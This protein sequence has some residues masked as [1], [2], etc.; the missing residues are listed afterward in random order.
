MF[1]RRTCAVAAVIVVGFA[2]SSWLILGTLDRGR[3]G[4]WTTPVASGTAG[5]GSSGVEEGS[6]PGDGPGRVAAFP[7]FV[8]FPVATAED[9]RPEVRDG[10]Y[11][12]GVE[13][14]G[15]SR[16]YPLNMLSNPERH[17]VNDDL[18]GQPI[19]V[20]WCG[21]CQ[22]PIV[23][24]RRMAGRTL[25]LQVPGTVYGENMVIQDAETGSEWPQLLGEALNGPLK[26]QSLQ[27][28]PSVWTAWKTWRTEHPDTSVLKLSHKVDY[29]RSDGDRAS[30]SRELRYLSSLQFGLVRG[31]KAL[32]VPLKELLR[33]PVVN[34]TIAGL[35]VVILFDAQGSTLTAFERRVGDSELT[36][37]KEK[38]GL[39]DDRTGSVWDP[40]TGRALRGALAGQR[41]RPVPGIV[42]HL[43]AWRAFHPESQVR[44][45]H[46]S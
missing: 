39:T 42:S 12:V 35:A 5:E 3:G 13:L 46:P 2:I 18:G 29:Y 32:S 31:G 36:F 23:Y 1:L 34:D 45:A 24:S 38:D 26:G 20:T 7:P 43:R 21:L 28:I 9:A 11:V 22:S 19:A 8:R 27:Q 15:E 6:G 41:L 40:V 30:G 10:D 4:G 25:L 16:A 17:V 37:R 33:Q 14:N 44:T